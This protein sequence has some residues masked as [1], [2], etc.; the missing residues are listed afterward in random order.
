MALVPGGALWGRAHLQRGVHDLV[1]GG[2]VRVPQELGLLLEC[3]HALRADAAD[4][5]GDLQDRGDGVLISDPATPPPPG[6]A[7]GAGH[8]AALQYLQEQ[9]LAAH[10]GR[11]APVDGLR[12]GQLPA[13]AQQHWDAG[14]LHR[15]P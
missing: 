2:E 10:H 6:S 13:V 12:E 1:D 4:G 5:G 9:S 15:T 8:G 11:F 3:Q 7:P 14:G